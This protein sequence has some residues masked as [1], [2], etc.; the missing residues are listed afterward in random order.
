[1]NL[2][3]FLSTCNAASNTMRKQDILLAIVYRQ[4]YV[5][6]SATTKVEDEVNEVSHAITIQQL[7]FT[8]KTTF[9]NQLLSLQSVL[10]EKTRW[11]Q[12]S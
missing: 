9:A 7:S 1:M 11:L 3:E 2:V 10:L 5:I 6:F 4:D 12:Q 8:N